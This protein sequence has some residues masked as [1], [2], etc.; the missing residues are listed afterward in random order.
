MNETEQLHGAAS[1]FSEMKILIIDDELANVALLE[2][3]LSDSGYTRVKSIMDPRLSIQTCAEFEPDV[4]LLDLRMPHMD[5][6]AVLEA[7]R[8]KGTGAFLPVIVLTA[9]IDAQSKYR[10][11][12]A[13]ATD[14]LLK[15]LDHLEVLLRMGLFMERRRI[16]YE[17]HHEKEKAEAASAAKDRFLAM[18]SHELRTP[19]TPVLIWASG[20]AQEPDL[21]PDLQDGLKMVC[22]NVELEAKMIDDMLDLTRITRGKLSLHRR[23]ADAHELVKHAIDIVRSDIEA[24]HLN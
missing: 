7:L 23:P 13:G 24:R 3:L 4:V 17:L 14:Y 12:R 22:R 1:R 10:A 11:L 9:D 6:F 5:G 19:L 21:S 16:E 2:D 18:A 20:T 8:A 15:P